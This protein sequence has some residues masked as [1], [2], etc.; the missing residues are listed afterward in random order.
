MDD[1]E[2]LATVAMKTTFYLGM[3]AKSNI[4]TAIAGFEAHVNM[5]VIQRLFNVMAISVFLI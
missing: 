5:I 1:L 2:L 3:P 4:V